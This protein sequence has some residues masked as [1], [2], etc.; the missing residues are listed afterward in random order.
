ML[1]LLLTVIV[2]YLQVTSLREELLVN[3]LLV[4]T[5]LVAIHYLSYK[6]VID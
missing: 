3:K 2:Q 5:E 1:T 4:I 6:V